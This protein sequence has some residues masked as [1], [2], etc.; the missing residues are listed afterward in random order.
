[1]KCNIGSSDPLVRPYFENKEVADQIM[2]V[3]AEN[4]VTYK[5]ADQIFFAVKRL[6][7]NIP[8]FPDGKAVK[9]ETGEIK[10]SE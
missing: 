10:S 6:L 2:Q 9:F 1:M 5:Q 4:H 3:I 8:V 7:K